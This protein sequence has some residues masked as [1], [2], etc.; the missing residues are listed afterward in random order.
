MQMSSFPSVS[1]DNGL[2]RKCQFAV[3]QRRLGLL[4][5]ILERQSLSQ[6]L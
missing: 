3:E 4:S 2:R 1:K 6:L 5:P